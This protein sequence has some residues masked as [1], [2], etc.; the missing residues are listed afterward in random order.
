[1]TALVL[2]LAALSAGGLTFLAG[3]LWEHERPGGTAD[4][5]DR[6]DLVR[7]HHRDRATR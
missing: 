7:R 6:I 4:L 2:L 3:A 1:M 5:S